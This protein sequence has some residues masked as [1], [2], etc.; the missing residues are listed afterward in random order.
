MRWGV[1]KQFAKGEKIAPKWGDLSEMGWVVGVFLSNRLQ[2]I[3]WQYVFD[4]E[5]SA[6]T[7]AGYGC[8][9]RWR[10]NFFKGIKIAPEWGD[11]RGFNQILGMAPSTKAQGIH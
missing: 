1:G 11:L 9:G 10:D 8:G 3:H 5:S 4:V 6:R 7:S 2:G